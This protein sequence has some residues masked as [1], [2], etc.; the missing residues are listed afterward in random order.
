MKERHSFKILRIFK[1]CTVKR[2]FEQSRASVRATT[3]NWLP[4]HYRDPPDLSSFIESSKSISHSAL[5]FTNPFPNTTDEIAQRCS[6]LY[7]RELPASELDKTRYICGAYICNLVTFS[8]FTIFAV[9]KALGK[10][11][12][13]GNKIVLFFCEYNNYYVFKTSITVRFLFHFL[14]VSDNIVSQ[15]KFLSLILNNNKNIKE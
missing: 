11:K 13:I 6:D 4:E 15:K 7:L 9:Y 12:I 2:K 3:F 10:P 8:L 5:T 1:S 14:I